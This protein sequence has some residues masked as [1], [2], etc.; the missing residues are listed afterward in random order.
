M[1]SE[2]K[3]NESNRL[4]VRLVESNRNCSPSQPSPT[5]S[6]DPFSVAINSVYVRIG[7]LGR[8]YNA[9]LGPRRARRPRAT[10]RAAHG[11]LCQ[12]TARI[13]RGDAHRSTPQPQTHSGKQSSDKSLSRPESCR[14]DLDCRDRDT[15]LADRFAESPR[16]TVSILPSPLEL[17][18]A[19][20]PVI[21]LFS[22][23]DCLRGTWP[24]SLY[25]FLNNRRL[26]HRNLP[27]ID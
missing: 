7:S 2:V 15:G 4:G 8:A 14:I 19:S 6:A 10:P 24:T 26:W 20:L 5:A 3:S 11:D 22:L 17:A 13:S 9:G 25:L 18:N 16:E 21:C 27:I 12:T 23:S 1:S